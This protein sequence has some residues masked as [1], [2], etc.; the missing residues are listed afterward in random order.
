MLPSPIRAFFVSTNVPI[1]PDV[2]QVGA[3]PQ[4]GERSDVSAGADNRVG[5]VGTDHPRPLADDDVR[6]CRVRADHRARG[7]RGRTPQLRI[8]LDGRVRFYADGY[9]D[10][11]GRRVEHADAGAHQVGVDPVAQPGGQRGELGPIVGAEALLGIAQ[12]MGGDR[13][14]GGREEIQNVGEIFLALVVRGCQLPERVAQRG[15]V[16]RVHAGVH[17]VDR[18]L[19]GRCIP[20]FDDAGDSAVFVTHDAAEAEWIVDPRGQHGCDRRR[21][22]M[23]VDHRHQRC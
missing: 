10:P 17:L 23:S 1:L 22:L 5:S 12:L 2:G 6:E 16:E 19:F 13:P 3:G 11:G 21:L 7:H 4:V 8:G 20:V 14:A 9:V 15:R 18:Q